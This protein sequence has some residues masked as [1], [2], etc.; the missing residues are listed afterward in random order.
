M[1]DYEFIFNA[2]KFPGDPLRSWILDFL[3]AIEDGGS[4]QSTGENKKPQIFLKRWGLNFSPQ[5]FS[6]PRTG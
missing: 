2:F 5:S 3:F 6:F 1:L 4:F